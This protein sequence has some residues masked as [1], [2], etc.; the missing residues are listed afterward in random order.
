MFQTGLV[1]ITFRQLS[2][3]QIV[4]LVSRA[5]LQAIEWGGDVHVPHGAMQAAR[6]VRAL[7]QKANLQ[8]AAYGSYYRVGHSEAEGLSFQSVLQTAQELGAPIIRVWAGKKNAEDAD[9]EY[10][11]LIIEESR[12]IAELATPAGVL[13]AYEFHGGTLTNTAAS[14]RELLKAAD[15]PNLKTLWQPR[16]GAS[17]PEALADLQLLLPWLCQLHAFQWNGTE[18]RP[19]EEGAAAWREY[20]ALADNTEKPR[21]ALIE[22]VQN[23][24][25]AQFLKD[26]QILKAWVDQAHGAT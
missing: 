9:D 8:V 6:E 23:D 5:E 26:A 3:T 20:L 14:A 17:T 25:P 10:R 2:P 21:P 24:A 19:L 13:V 4:D 12:R 18:R 16:V 22:F 11:R 15:H 1:S 7:T